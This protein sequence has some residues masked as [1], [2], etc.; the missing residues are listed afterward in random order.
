MTLKVSPVFEFISVC[1]GRL[2]I[3]L[4]DES[5]ILGFVVKFI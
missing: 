4:D 5:Q 2:N 1:Y 3:K